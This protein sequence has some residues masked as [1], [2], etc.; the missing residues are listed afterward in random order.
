M[1]SAQY[2]KP[3]STEYDEYQS[4]NN[5]NSESESD[6]ESSTVSSYENTIA[7]GT[8]DQCLDGGD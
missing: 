8:D 1:S 7:R 6:S 5:S 2:Y 4:D 3:Y